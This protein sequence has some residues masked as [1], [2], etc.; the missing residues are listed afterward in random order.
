MHHMNEK[1]IKSYCKHITVL[2]AILFLTKYIS[3]YCFQLML[4]QGESMYPTYRNCQI[5]VLDKKPVNLEIGDVIAFRCE[6]LDSFLVK[7]IVA[8]AGDIVQI[9][10]GALYVN[11]IAYA[12][13]KNLISYPGIASEP[14]QLT[15]NEY[16]VLGDN[17]E[18]S[19]DSRYSEVGIV[20]NTDII[21]KVYPQVKSYA[22]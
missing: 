4:I 7:R 20:K 5:V 8:G 16:F 6:Y 21:G 14:I 18:K 17:F 11:D 10:G 9:K 2:L 12:V 1:K 13:E 15:E 19:K 22:R 3:M